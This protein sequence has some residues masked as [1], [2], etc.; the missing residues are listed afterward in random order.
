MVFV[1]GT[2]VFFFDGD[3]SYS[4]KRQMI[5]SLNRIG[6]EEPPKRVPINQHMITSSNLNDFVTSTSKVLF[7]KLKLPSGFLQKDPYAWNDYNNFLRALSIVPELKVI[8]D[9][10][11]RGV[12]LIQE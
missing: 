1:A 2:P 3:L 8:N 9:H 10:A 7:Q 6:D 11:E 12:A 4:K 5:Q